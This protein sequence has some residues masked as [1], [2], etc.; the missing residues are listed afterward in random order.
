MGAMAGRGIKTVR[1]GE[2]GRYR[3]HLT[4]ERCAQLD[5]T[6]REVLGGFEELRGLADY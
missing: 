1:Q 6:F 5:A 4:A 2:A 3:E